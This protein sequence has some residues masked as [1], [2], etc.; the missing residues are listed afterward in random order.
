MHVRS[1]ES[2]HA[3][4]QRE[5]QWCALH[6]RYQHENLVN[7]LL[8]MK[9]FDTFYPTCSRIHAWK[10]RKKR[11]SEAL[12]PGYLF[13]ANIGAHRLEVVSTPG[14][15]AIV[16]IAGTPAT[17]PNDEIEAIRQAL[18]SPYPVEPHLYVNEGDGVRIVQGPLSGVQGILVRKANSARLVLAIQMLGRAAAV[19]IDSA[20]VDSLEPVPPAPERR[21]E[22]PPARFASSGVHQST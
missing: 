17:I 21:M 11:V 19:E 22:G 9:G 7:G 4:A 20:C 1:L 14:V 10:D 3:P 13:V 5:K 15:C 8:R 18:L 16:S 2:Y 6:T 12:F